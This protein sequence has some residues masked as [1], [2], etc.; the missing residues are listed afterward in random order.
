MQKSKTIII[1]HQQP[2]TTFQWPVQEDQ[3]QILPT[4]AHWDILPTLKQMIRWN[5]CLVYNWFA[6]KIHQNDCMLKNNENTYRVMDLTPAASTTNGIYD[7]T[8]SSVILQSEACLHSWHYSWRNS[9]RI[10][11]KKK[12]TKR[13]LP[14]CWLVLTPTCLWC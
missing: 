3:C 13:W 10:G 9:T 4:D 1:T 5:C 12:S 2:Q 6:V 8:I 11:H 14:M 7:V